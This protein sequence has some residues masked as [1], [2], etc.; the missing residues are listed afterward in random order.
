MAPPVIG[1]PARSLTLRGEPPR[2]AINQAYVQALEAAGCVPI[3]IP[4]IQDE[5]RL[6]AL[7]ERLDGL[8]FPG[9]ADVAPAEYGEQPID[10]LNDVDAPRDRTELVLA[11]WAAS[12]DRPV[13]GIC[14]GQQLL[15]VALGGTLYQDLLH[16]GVTTVHH[17][18]DDGRPRNAFIHTVRLDPGSHLAQLIDETTVDVNSLHHQA[19]KDVAP[20]LKVTGR[21]P[22]GVIEAME[23]ADHRFLVTVQWHPEEIAD[24][25]WV[26]RLFRA[27]ARAAARD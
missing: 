22:D 20:T 26:Q 7:Y 11:R 2:F 14:R 27:F 4:L 25:P 8:V 17:A 24:L 16:Q 19:V 10:N 9:G 5:Q 18:D 21:A 6:R 23:S 13:L 3:M 1:L 15:N 12:E